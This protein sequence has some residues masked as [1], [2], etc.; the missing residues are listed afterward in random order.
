MWNGWESWVVIAQWLEH[1]RLKP[2]SDLGSIPSGF[3]ESFSHSFLSL[4]L[5]FNILLLSWSPN[6][7]SVV[8]LLQE[9]VPNSL[10]VVPA[11]TIV[12]V[13]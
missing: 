2:V 11:H 8:P 10:P 6:S 5:E 9:M 7:L 1:R 3:Q 13:T 4:S 12:L